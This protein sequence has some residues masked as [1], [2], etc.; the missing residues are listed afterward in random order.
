MRRR[1]ARVLHLIGVHV[2]CRVEWVDAPLLVASIL[3]DDG[4]I[5]RP[6]INGLPGSRQVHR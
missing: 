1:L 3:L 5:W 2:A 6:D 4:T